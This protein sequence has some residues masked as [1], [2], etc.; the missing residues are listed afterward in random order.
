[1]IKTS[2][3]RL[4]DVIN[5]LDGRRLG[6]A[7]DL[8]VELDQGRVTALVVPGPARF[9]G[10]FGRDKDFVIPWDNIVKIGVDVILVEVDNYTAGRSARRRGE[11]SRQAG[12]L[13]GPWPEDRP[14]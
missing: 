12:I 4:R 3:L 7:V 6:N 8:E 5:V 11:R 14:T 13:T 9:L 2:E 1:M 10:L